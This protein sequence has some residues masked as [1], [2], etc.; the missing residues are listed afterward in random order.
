MVTN[1]QLA[2][3]AERLTRNG[4]SVKTAAD[5]PEAGKIIR[6]LIRELSPESISFG[7]SET[8]FAAGVIDEL[9][10]TKDPRL[11][12]GFDR[13]MPRPERLEI[14]RQALL[15]DLFLT[16]INAVT[17]DGHL[18]W[19]DMIG[20]R[21]AP[22]IF[23]PRHVIL[24]AGRNKIVGNDDEARARI[25]Q[26]AAPKNALKH[27]DFKT[28]CQKTGVCSDCNSPDRICNAWVSLVKC[29]PRGRI[30]VLFVDEELGL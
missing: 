23:G 28:P 3:C 9:R 16:G 29:F 10:R 7:D 8:L 30:T 22:V 4:F 18:H 6:A 5:A 17:M 11:I 1:E 20:N 21:V 26:I 12:D 15:V 2:R 27:T 25:R 14:R 19:L 13:S 24:I